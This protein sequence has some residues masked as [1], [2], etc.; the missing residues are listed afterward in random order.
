MSSQQFSFQMIL[1]KIKEENFANRTKGSLFEKLSKHL[2]KERDTGSLY[3]K[4]YLW[5]EW[6][7]KDG[8][9]CGIDLVIQT[10][11]G[12]YIAVQCKFYENSKV[13]LQDLSTY[14]TK[15]QSGIGEIE[16]SKGIIIST[17]ELTQNAENEIKQIS[18]NKSI[19]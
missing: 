2:L 18:R 11:D 13:D 7:K 16:F 1:D 12:D 5:D 10:N 6:E 8:Q 17:S 14:F 4:I 15:L 3:S 9:D 19:G